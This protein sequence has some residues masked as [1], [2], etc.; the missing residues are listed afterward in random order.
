MGGRSIF[1]PLIRFQSLRRRAAVV[2]SILL[3]RTK[4][5]GGVS[6]P[7]FPYALLADRRNLS[8]SDAPGV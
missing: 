2:I 1:A 8:F 3:C 5:I 6:A 7:V 4:T